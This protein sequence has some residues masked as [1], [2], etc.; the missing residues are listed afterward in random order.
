VA[1]S[2]APAEK[3]LR[4]LHLVSASDAGGLS[5]YVHDLCAAMHERGHDVR[6]A[7][8]RGA[9]HPLFA[10][11]GFP[12]IDVPLSGGLPSLWKA[13]R[14]LRRHLREHPVDVLHTHYR[15]ATLVARR[16]QDSFGD[17]PILYTVHLSDMPLRWPGKLWTDFGDHA[18]VA[19]EDARQWTVNKARMPADRV[20]VIPHGL[21]EDKWP[22]AD[23][24]AKRL[25]RES[26][27]LSP[28]DRVAC[29]VGRLDYPKNE[30]WLVDLLVAAKGVVPNLK[31]LVAGSGPGAES[32]GQHVAHR[33]VHDMVKYL[34]ELEHPL[35]VYQAADAFLLPSLREGFS[36]GCA[37]AMCAGV[38]VLRTR[39]AGTHELIVENVTGRSCDIDRD[40]FVAAGVEFLKDGESLS[41]MGR[42]AA[43]HVRQHLTFERQLAG[44]LAL[45]RRLAKH[46]PAADETIKPPAAAAPI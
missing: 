38:P 31:L 33:G 26:F 27:G 39:T 23:A 16:L 41:R 30:D 17:P 2:F 40:A 11:A 37:E 8:A 20:T 7:G 10:K 22:L 4:V 45:Y 14:T 5:R 18:H 44:T 15:R 1:V 13:I 24:A 42:A 3:P 25:A 6:V 35:P 34:G 36:F 32:F 28:D 46:A 9:W 29:Y 19:S 43:H 12:W 21:R